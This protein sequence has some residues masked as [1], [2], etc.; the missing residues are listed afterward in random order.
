MTPT[1]ARAVIE[2]QRTRLNVIRYELAQMPKADAAAAL[3]EFAAM[4]RETEQTVRDTM[5]GKQE[6][7]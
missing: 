5:T 1:E 4:L 2:Y 7:K 3:A 6:G